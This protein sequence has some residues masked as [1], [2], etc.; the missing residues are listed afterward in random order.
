AYSIYT[1]AN[2]FTDTGILGLYVG[3]GAEMAGELAHVLVDE[4]GRLAD[5]IE[6]LEVARAK[7]QLRAQML[8]GL[9]SMSARAEHLAATTLMF[10]EPVPHTHLVE[11]IEAVTEDDVARIARTIT[12]QK[13]AI[14]AIGPGSGLDALGPLAALAA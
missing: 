1:F 12:A 14:S 4:I 7:A 10:G 5:T 6:P 3:T 2:V 8:F 11:R 13:A 9:E